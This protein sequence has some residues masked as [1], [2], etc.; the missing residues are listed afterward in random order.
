[1]AIGRTSTG[2]RDPRLRE[3]IHKD[4]ASYVGM[5]ATPS[6]YASYKVVGPVLPLLERMMPNQILSTREI[7]QGMLA[8][9]RNGYEKRVLETRDIRRVVGPRARESD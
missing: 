8:V 9:A 2:L 3:I 7:G 4:M 6:G 5:D 1:M